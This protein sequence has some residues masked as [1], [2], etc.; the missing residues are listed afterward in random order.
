MRIN[1]QRMYNV[2]LYLKCEKN[3][4]LV[5]PWCG[6]CGVQQVGNLRRRLL[7]AV[8]AAHRTAIWTVGLGF[9]LLS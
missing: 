9:P 1:G 4:L 8:Q 6:A 2:T 3:I 5:L 7:T